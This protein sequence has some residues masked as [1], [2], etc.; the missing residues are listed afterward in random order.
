MTMIGAAFSDASAPLARIASVIVAGL[1]ARKNVATTGGLVIAASPM[2]DEEPCSWFPRWRAQQ[3]PAHGR[4]Q[5]GGEDDT[6]GQGAD[7]QGD[8][9]PDGHRQRS[10]PA[11]DGRL[12]QPQ[13]V[14]LVV[15]QRPMTQTGIKASR[16]VP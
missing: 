10:A 6:Q 16:T 4:D 2:L 14:R 3:A 8:L 9:G 11:H 15:R 1:T 12:T 5:E 7:V 13:R